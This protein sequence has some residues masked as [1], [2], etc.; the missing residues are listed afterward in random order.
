MPE[1]VELL[2]LSTLTVL[3]SG[4][5]D[6]REGTVCRVGDSRETAIV[7]GVR[8]EIAQREGPGVQLSN[9]S[10][11]EEGVVPRR[12]TDDGVVLEGPMGGVYHRQSPG[13]EDGSGTG[14]HNCD[15]SRWTC[16][17]RRMDVKRV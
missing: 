12:A 3:Q 11:N 16:A 5:L 8:P 13:H 2:H 7:A 6:A 4:V 1:T 17:R 14:R 9:I 15:I 10:L